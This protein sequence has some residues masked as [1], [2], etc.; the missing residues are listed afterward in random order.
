MDWTGWIGRYEFEVDAGVFAQR[1]VTILRACCENTPKS[2]VQPRR[3]QIDVHKPGTRN[4]GMIEMR[5][6]LSTQVANDR[7]G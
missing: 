2:V 3:L 5:Q 7:V 6:V 4:F 1:G